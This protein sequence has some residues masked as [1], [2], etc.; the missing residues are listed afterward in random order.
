MAT[1][2]HRPPRPTR[3]PTSSAGAIDTVLAVFADHPAGSSASAPTP[4]STSTPCS[5]TAPRTATTCSPATSTTRRSRGSAG[6]ATSRATA[7]C[8]AWSIRATIRYLPWLENTALVVV[9][10]VDVDSGAPVEVS[11]RR[12]LQRQVDAAADAGYVAMIGSEIEFFLFKESYDD[13]NADGYRDADAELAVPRGLPHPPDD[14][15]GG[16]ARRDPARPRRRRA[17]GRVLQGRGRARPARAQP[18]LPT[19]PSRWPTSTSIFKNAVKEIAHVAR[20]VGDVHGQAA[21]RRRRVELPHPLQ[22][23]GRRRRATSLMARR[24]TAI[25]TT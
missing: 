15:G 11:P 19:A 9:D 14:Q 18:H 23:V 17:A 21:L 3:A 6:R 12:M 13:A 7:T 8:A 4:G 22:P 24:R 1:N 25:R 10:L 20:Q 16:R 5:R 2:T